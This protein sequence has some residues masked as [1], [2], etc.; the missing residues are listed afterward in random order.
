MGFGPFLAVVAITVFAVMT[1]VWVLSLILSDASIV[2]VAWGPGFIVV[3]AV[4]IVT[5]AGDRN[6]SVLVLILVT[7]WGIRLAT[8]IG[9]RNHGKPEDFRYQQFRKNAGRSFWWRSYFTVFLLQG[10]VMWLVSIP[11]AAVLTIAHPPLITGWDVAALLI[12]VI[13]FVF[14]A[15]GDWQLRRFKANPENRGKL[16]T[17]GFWSVTRHPNYFGDAMVWW[18]F[19]LFAVSVGAWW[20]LASPIVM[21][22]FLMRVSGVAMLERTL[23]TTKPGY[24]EYIQTTPAFF[25]RIPRLTRRD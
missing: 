2:D 11:I 3:A 9:T 19:G 10:G 12:W 16:L 6:R 17:S 22:I 20:A 18:G 14:E 8:H 24:Q 23:V 21:S 5:G 15:G 7:L 25:P 1:M 13:G 4:G